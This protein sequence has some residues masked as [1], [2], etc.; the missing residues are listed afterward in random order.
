M[1]K[2][3]LFWVHFACI[4]TRP[5][6]PVKV[7]GKNDF[8]RKKCLV[9]G[10]HV[11]GWDAVLCTMYT[12]HMMCFPY[13]AEFDKN[14]FLRSL[15]KGLDGIPM[16]RGEIDLGASRRIIQLLNEDKSVCLFPEGTRNP[17]V[18]CLQ[19]FRTGVALYALKTHSPIRPFYIWEKTKM[20]RKNYMIFGDEFTLEQFYDKP[21]S[22]ALLLEAT[23]CVKQHVEDLRIQLNGILEQKGVKRR[24]RTAKEK[25]KIIAYNNK[26]K[27]LAEKLNA[28][29]N[30]EKS[31]GEDK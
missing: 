4:V 14:W 10:N 5:F 26:Q 27:T 13:K 11:S 1:K 28:Q 3:T 6:F 18:D 19:E 31:V 7:I 8:D 20:F 16:H 25:A 17:N 23:E 29:Q 24:P 12:K 15:F 30:A 9:V 2:F 22:K 21:I